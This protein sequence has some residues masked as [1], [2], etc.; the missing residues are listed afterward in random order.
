MRRL[1]GAQTVT[2]HVQ[3][4]TNIPR[5]WP[6]YQKLWQIQLSL[7]VLHETSLPTVRRLLRQITTVPG[8]LHQLI[9]ENRHQSH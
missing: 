1:N 7:K 3:K 6:K 8:T 4:S 9:H 5:I 2:E